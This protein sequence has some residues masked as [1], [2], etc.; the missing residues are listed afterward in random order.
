MSVEGPCLHLENVGKSFGRHRALVGVSTVFSPGQV[1]T[2]LGPNGAGKSTLL[3]VLATLVRPTTGTL[4]WGDAPLHPTAPARAAIGY[5]GHDPGLYGDLGAFDNLALFGALHGR[6]IAA[7]AL[8]ERVGLGHVDPTAP[9][10]TYSRGMQQRLALARALLHEP[11]ILLFDEPSA[12]L[13]PTGAEW[14][15]AQL[16]AQRADGRIV[17]VVTHDLDAVAP[18]AD[19]V[20]VLRRGRLVYD[21]PVPVPLSGEDLRR[22]YQDKTAAARVPE[23]T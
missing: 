19:Q 8:L 18:L 6:Q 4:R 23:G 16:A 17:V 15:A 21:A 20:L 13:D 5:V 12:A 10:R 7:P 2:I 11:P 3:G 14:L 9:V 22:L 1:A